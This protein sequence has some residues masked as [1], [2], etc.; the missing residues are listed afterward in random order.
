MIRLVNLV[1]FLQ[2]QLEIRTL[3]NSFSDALVS[4][5][6]FFFPRLCT[7][8]RDWHRNSV[9][10]QQG[11]KA[12][13]KSIITPKI[14]LKVGSSIFENPS[15]SSNT[16]YIDL[17]PSI[18]DACRDGTVRLIH[19]TN[20]FQALIAHV[21][22]VKKIKEAERSCFSLITGQYQIRGKKSKIGRE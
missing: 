15:N 6:L 5:I 22:Q 11:L 4:V 13:E 20:W 17:F 21:G 7:A 14:D 3:I 2:A 9:Q 8:I 10:G 12:T 1:L 18:H 16:I 19:V